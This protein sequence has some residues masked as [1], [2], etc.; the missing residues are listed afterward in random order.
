MHEHK[1][2]PGCE[3]LHQA[4][5]I[6]HFPRQEIRLNAGFHALIVSICGLSLKSD[7]GNLSTEGCVWKV[8]LFTTLKMN[9]V[10]N[11]LVS[12]DTKNSSESYLEDGRLHLGIFFYVL[13]V[14]WELK[15]Y[16]LKI[17]IWCT[18]DCVS[19]RSCIANWFNIF[20]DVHCYLSNFAILKNISWS[21]SV[22]LKVTSFVKW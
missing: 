17:W 16:L 4:D 3:V 14:H 1:H 9:A 15:M 22:S 8:T 18:E 5:C 2:S 6:D 13:F 21:L 12:M 10:H 19:Q 20:I 11:D 7:S